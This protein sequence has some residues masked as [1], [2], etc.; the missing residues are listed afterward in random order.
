MA[1]RLTTVRPRIQYAQGRTVAS[2]PPI[3]NQRTRG[4]QWERLRQRTLAQDHGLC[5]A[6][7]A[8]GLVTLAEEVDH[9]TPL[10]AGGTDAEDNRQ[11]LCR[12]CHAAKTAHEAGQRSSGGVLVPWEPAGPPRAG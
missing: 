1:A 5:R 9:I 12:P 10:W 11:A 4:N 8:I 6:C 7:R 2:A 3:T